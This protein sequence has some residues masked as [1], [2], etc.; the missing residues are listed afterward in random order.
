MDL[1]FSYAHLFVLSLQ[2]LD[3]CPPIN[4]MDTCRKVELHDVHQGKR[5]YIYIYDDEDDDDDV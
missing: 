2:A 5:I 3:T 1:L 4:Y